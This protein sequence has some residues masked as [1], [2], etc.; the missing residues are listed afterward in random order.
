M[1]IALVLAHME[2]VGMPV[3][4]DLVHAEREPLRRHVR[5]LEEAAQRCCPGAPPFSIS[6]NSEVSELLYTV[7]RLPVPPQAQ[8]GKS[9]HVSVGVGV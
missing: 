7:L 5:Q 4:P 1:P 6:S 8:R 3:D 9:S 2:C